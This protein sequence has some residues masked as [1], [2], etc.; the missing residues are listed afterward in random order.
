MQEKNINKNVLEI[1]VAIINK[2]SNSIIA[3]NILFHHDYDLYMK[4]NK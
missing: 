1:V 3:A 2:S 4:S